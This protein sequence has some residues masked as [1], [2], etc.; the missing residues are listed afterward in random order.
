M[1][2]EEAELAAAAAEDTRFSFYDLE[3]HDHAPLSKIALYVARAVVDRDAYCPDHM[4]ANAW[5]HE[6]SM[7]SPM[8]TRHSLSGYLSKAATELFDPKDEKLEK[9]LKSKYDFKVKK[10]KKKKGLRKWKAT[11]YYSYAWGLYN[12]ASEKVTGDP[13]HFPKDHQTALAVVEFARRELF[14]LIGV[15]DGGLTL[16]MARRT[17]MKSLAEIEL[18]EKIQEAGFDG[19][20]LES[21]NVREILASYDL[22]RRGVILETE[23][24]WTYRVKHLRP[25]ES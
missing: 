7:D 3:A 6:V 13:L 22:Y 16:G 5:G 23:R 10:A 19:Y 8:A 2:D 21:G 14:R 15:D 18:L 24:A 9:D 12:H 17:D 11:R 1:I 20:R 25:W 4:A